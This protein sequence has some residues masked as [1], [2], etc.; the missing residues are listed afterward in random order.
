MPE[1]LPQPRTTFVGQRRALARVRQF[2]GEHRLVTVTGVGGVGKTRLALRVAADAELGVDHE[3]VWTDLASIEDPRLVAASVCAAAGVPTAAGVPAIDALRRRLRTARALIVLDNCEHL[4]DACA[5][6]APALLDACPHLKILA[7]SREPLGVAGEMAWPLP[8]LGVP[9]P[10]R[11]GEATVDEAMT[12]DAVRLFVDRARAAQPDFELTPERVPAVVDICQR[13]DAIPLAL[14]LAAARVRVLSPEQV[15]ERLGQGLGLLRDAGRA[16]PPR[17][18]TMR[19]ALEWSHD[20]LSPPERMLFR[21]LAA[22]GGGTTLEGCE[23]V[24]A[25]DGLDRADVLDVLTQL[26]D[27]SL[28]LAEPRDGVTRFRLLEPVAQFAREKLEASDDLTGTGQ[29]HAAYY[30]AVLE[31]EAPGLRGP[32]RPAVLA[33]LGAE[34]GNLRR[35]W[36]RAVAVADD[37]VLARLAGTLF[38]FWN[39]AGHFTEGRVRCE[40][41]LERV[42]AAHRATADLLYAA[43][44]LAWMQGAHAAARARLDA[45]RARCRAQHRD[46]LLPLVLR[47]LAGVMLSAGDLPA[48]ATLYEESAGLLKRQADRE[49]DLAL[50]SVLLSDVREALGDRAAARALRAEGR[51]RFARVGDPWG[52]SLADFSLAVA[53]GTTGDLDGARVHAHDA[54]ALQRQSGDLWNLGTSLLVLGEIELLAGALAESGDLLRESLE[55]LHDVGDQVSIGHGL[56]CLAE[57]ERRRGPHAPR[58]PTGRRRAR[59]RRTRRGALSLRPGRRR[60]GTA[61]G[62]ASSGGR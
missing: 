21:R 2:V 15:A 37:D 44:T 51:S 1:A 9:G 19:A 50:A 10:G 45:C 29:R 38:W 26:G 27:K 53:A 42:P 58:R 56:R 24:C 35:V 43:G 28:V 22:F 60:R 11:A 12:H 57:V 18:R 47:E 32:D 14:E 6:L 34:H 30:L 40:E 23:A 46:D 16:A 5:E 17:H 59:A 25:G 52:L 3:V 49:W 61:T 20:L 31:A 13:V 54:L 4:I 48:A 8:S 55:A 36:D 39:F 33:R 41:A 62:R 7:T